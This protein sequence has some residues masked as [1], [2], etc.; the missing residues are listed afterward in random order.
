MTLLAEKQVHASEG[1]PYVMIP[2]ERL[3]TIRAAMEDGTWHEGT[4]VVHN[5]KRGWTSKVAS[6]I[7]LSAWDCV[8]TIG[9]VCPLFEQDQAITVWDMGSIPNHFDGEAVRPCGGIHIYAAAFH[10]GACLQGMNTM[11]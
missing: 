5:I 4:A 1:N 11:L 9:W 2:D 8:S 6:T 10:G 3:A 7:T